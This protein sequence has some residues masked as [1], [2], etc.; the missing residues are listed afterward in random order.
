MWPGGGDV[1]P[2]PT[3]RERR[4]RRLA[5]RLIAVR[6]RAV[7][8]IIEDS[9]HNDSVRTGLECL[10]RFVRMRVQPIIYCM[11]KP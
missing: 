6:W 2:S 11:Q 8:A 3:L 1:F 5:R 7:F 10:L 9:V 4:H